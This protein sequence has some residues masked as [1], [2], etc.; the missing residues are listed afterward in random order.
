MQRTFYLRST[1]LVTVLGCLAAACG[2]DPAAKKP[3]GSETTNNNASGSG[4]SGTT[5]GG[6][7]NVSGTGSAGVPTVPGMT[8]G[9]LTLASGDAPTARLHRL[10]T[11]ELQHSL[12]D[13]LGDGIPLKDVDPD[14]VVDGF[15][16]IGAGIVTTAPAAVSLY[17]SAVR[18]AT[19]YMFM[20]PARLSAQISCVPTGAT[21]TACLNK[22]VA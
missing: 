10:T 18:A 20:D 22:V 19:D 13:L 7:G 1:I 16:S 17:E 11:S 3:A 5:S 12:Q 6:A 8:V 9:G 2:S 15:A 14:N 21:D 4:G